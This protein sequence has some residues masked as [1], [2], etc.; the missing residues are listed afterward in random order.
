MPIDFRCTQC[1]RLLR[2][3]D[4]TAGKQAKCPECGR[5]MPIPAVSGSSAGGAPSGAAGPL[6]SAPAD[7]GY[8]FPPLGPLA[9]AGLARP[10]GAVRPT[11]LDVGDIFRPVVVGDFAD[12]SG[13]VL[14]LS[15]LTMT[16]T[17][18]FRGS[19]TSSSVLTKG[20]ASP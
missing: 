20:V 14:P 19:A 6:P 2:T 1:G 8:P 16:S 13:V 15:Y 11:M 3:G 17:L 5:V 7:S 9:P 4:E 12:Q 18:R 10:P